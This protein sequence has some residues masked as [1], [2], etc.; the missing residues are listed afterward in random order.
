MTVDMLATSSVSRLHEPVNERAN[1]ATNGEVVRYYTEA[2]PDYR[3]WSRGFN[4]HFG[5]FRSGMNV[6]DLEAMLEQ[7]NLEVAA[8]LGVLGATAP[9]RV[10]DLGCGVGATMRTIAGA[11]APL[12]LWGVSLV[13]WQIAAAT[14]ATRESPARRRLRYLV[15]D[16]TRT[17][18]ADGSF[19]G[20]YALE[21]SC[22]A[23][24]LDKEPLLT[25]MHRVLRP[26]GRFVV[27]DAFL[28]TTRMNLFTRACYRALCACWSL[29]TW[30]EIH[31]F[32]EAARRLGFRD[33]RVE[34]ISANVAPSVL[35]VPATMYRFLAQAVGAGA[36]AIHRKRWE[37]M[38]A[39]APLLG[40]AMD[41]S[42]S[43]YFIVSG[44]KAS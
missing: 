35:H 32:S 6:R 24:G 23:P 11:S 16:Y 13:P 19:D 30:G 5:Y 44:V 28:R 29:E 14:Q 2:G 33:V 8:R 27:A 38:L 36:G 18:L 40:F 31:Q 4:M 7:M 37:N 20:V 12:Q 17:P 1:S 21:S 9:A 10:L 41:R 42:K 3:M 43:G 39:G 26:G 15:A 22:Y 25:E 34:D